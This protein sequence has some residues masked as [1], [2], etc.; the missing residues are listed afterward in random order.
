MGLLLQGG[1]GMV[2]VRARVEVEGR[3]EL[4][5]AEAASL[6]R[7]KVLHV[8]LLVVMVPF[9]VAA[10][11]NVGMVAPVFWLAGVIEACWGSAGAGQVCKEVVKVTGRWV[12]TVIWLS[13]FW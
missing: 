10:N 1:G 9:S 13:Q 7:T 5:D 8:L 11:G 3:V 2:L 4:D 12:L 6:K